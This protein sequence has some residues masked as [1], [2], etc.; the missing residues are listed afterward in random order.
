MEIYLK[1]I[2]SENIIKNI[3]L[4]ILLISL[5]NPINEYLVNNTTLSEDTPLAGDSLVAISILA[6]VACFGNFAFTYEKIHFKSFPE[7]MLGHAITGIVM[8]IIGISIIFTSKLLEF[9]IGE[10]I[11]IHIL[12]ILLYISMV[13]Y[14]VWDLLK[15]IRKVREEQK[16]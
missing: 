6:V 9:I 14:D 5:M 7:R 2:L 13:L 11:I 10:F 1:K 16:T 3:F 8:L 4:I 15:A 12:L